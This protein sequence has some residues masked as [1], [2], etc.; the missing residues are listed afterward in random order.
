MST[1]LVVFDFAKFAND[2]GPCSFTEWVDDATLEFASLA[3]K[4]N[5]EI[6]LAAVRIGIVI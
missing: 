5:K 1:E 6:V 2:H 3:L 4:D